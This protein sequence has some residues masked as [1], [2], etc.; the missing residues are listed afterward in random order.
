MIIKGVAFLIAGAAL[1]TAFIVGYFGLTEDSDTLRYIAL[2]CCAIA[3]API[4]FVT[5]GFSRG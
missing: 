3:F 2:G 4:A 1:A 5:M